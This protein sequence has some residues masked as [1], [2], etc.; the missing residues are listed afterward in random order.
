MENEGFMMVAKIGIDNRKNDDSSS[1]EKTKKESVCSNVIWLCSLIIMIVIIVTYVF[2]VRAQQVSDPFRSVIDASLPVL[3]SDI[4]V[5]IEGVPDDL[6]VGVV[7]SYT[8]TIFHSE[9]VDE[10]LGWDKN[11]EGV[12]VARWRLE[13]AGTNITLRVVSDKGTESG[14]RAAVSQLAAD[15]AGAI[16]ALTSGEHTK[17]LAEEAAETGI[18]IIF[19][20][21]S[22][23]ETGANAWFYNS[24]NQDTVKQMIQYAQTLECNN[25]FLLSTNKEFNAYVTLAAQDIEEFTIVASYGINSNRNIDSKGT[26]VLMNYFID[27]INSRGENT[28]GDNSAD[29]AENLNKDEDMDATMSGKSSDETQ[30]GEQGSQDDSQNVDEEP[31]ECILADAAGKDTATIVIKL[32]EAGIELPIITT[33]EAQNYS[34]YEAI[35]DNDGYSLLT[36]IYSVGVADNV[37]LAIGS[38]TEQQYNAAGVF[39]YAIT[40]MKQ[41]TAVTSLSVDN[42]FKEHGSYADLASHD[43]L[44]A[45]VIAAANANS[46]NPED[47]AM[48]LSTLVL[49]PESDPVSTTLDFTDQSQPIRES[50]IIQADTYAEN[51]VT[52]GQSTQTNS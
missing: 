14:A 20:Y 21:E 29:E 1:I 16:I 9:K 52:W 42:T 39:N 50:Y 24:S 35:N 32:R 46:T 30:S 18:P 7:V 23:F 43:A 13:Q 5:E 40:L 3:E 48:V 27:K 11:G 25:A 10:G 12:S 19:P 22:W 45:I 38:G 4:G 17:A 44:F 34:F 41:D 33:N 28:D 36:E 26:T 8:E 15:G 49:D 37:S 2:Y 47:I 31:F 51:R 6:V